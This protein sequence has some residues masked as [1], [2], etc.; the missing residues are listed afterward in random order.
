MK[1]FAIAATIVFAGVVG[2]ALHTSATQAGVNTLVVDRSDDANVTTCDSN[3]ANDCTLRGA[4]NNANA[5]A[6]GDRIEFDIPPGGIVTIAT[7][8]E[9]PSITET[10]AID[11]RTQPDA[12]S[13]DC[14]E[15]QSRPCVILDGP[16][17]D[18]QASGLYIENGADDV[19]IR[20]LAIGGYVTA[21]V[22]L[23][24]VDTEVAQNWIGTTNGTTG[25]GNN[26]GILIAEDAVGAQIGLAGAGNVISGNVIYGVYI[27]GQEVTLRGNRIGL[28][29]TGNGALGNIYG[30]YVTPLTSDIMVG[31]SLAG[32][33]NMIA[34]GWYGVSAGGT[35]DIT[36]AG[37]VFSDHQYHALLIVSAVGVDIGGNFFQDSGL[38]ENPLGGSNV[39]LQDVDDVTYTGNDSRDAYGSGL[40][41]VAGTGIQIGG[42]TLGERNTFSFNGT[43]ESDGWGVEIMDAINVT[44]E[45]N[46]VG[47]A[48]NGVTGEPNQTGGVLLRDVDTATVGGDAAGERNLISSNFGPAI[49]L[50]QVEDDE[51]TEDV[52][53]LGNYLGVTAAGDAALGNDWGVLMDGAHDNTVGPNNLISGNEIGLEFRGGARDNVVFGNLIGTAAN[54]VDDIGNDEEGVLITDNAR[55]ITIGGT[56]PGDGNTIAYSGGL[57]EP[58]VRLESG[59]NGNFVLQNGIYSSAGEGIEITFETNNAQLPPVL[60]SAEYG[61]TDIVL[62]F[63][64]QVGV[65]YRV[66][67]FA[68]PA[69]DTGGTGEGKLYLGFA[70]VIGTGLPEEEEISIPASAPAN[71]VL[72][73]TATHP[74]VGTSEFS[75]CVPITGTPPTI[76][77]SPAPTPIGQTPTQSPSPSP[78]PT[79]APALQ[80]DADCDGGIDLDDVMEILFDLANITEAPCDD[81]ANANCSASLDGNDATRVLAYIS[82]API[83]PP[84]GCP[85]VGS[86]LT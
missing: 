75:N 30:I 40:Q 12:T 35:S 23:N 57:L 49:E 56:G 45:G 31:G 51:S 46:W 16:G 64:G 13:G 28:T 22:V 62:T 50:S 25:D 69:C 83:T 78:S 70:S 19:S 41:I 85:Q 71:S 26:T 66:E 76:T 81:R 38:A 59:T 67:F 48:N 17:D 1:L 11:G 8:S 37:N 77:P 2:F 73:A 60:L 7:T 36:V 21:I 3:V 18:S 53:I 68:S 6:D 44:I 34:N 72:T 15:E 52:S 10:V 20:G 74:L 63:T 55:D 42:D 86:P 33:G 65:T 80:G 84:S 61:S 14:F 5:D 29:A 82:G 47:V 58:G 27:S 43:G 79:A 54:G 24:G 9:L 4:I 39:R 32:E